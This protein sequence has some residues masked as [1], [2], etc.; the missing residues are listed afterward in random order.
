VSDTGPGIPEEK[1]PNIFERFYRLDPSRARKASGGTGLGLSIAYWITRSH[2]GNIEVE[3]KLGVG[4]TFTMRLPRIMDN[5]SQ[6]DG[7]MSATED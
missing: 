7:V 2:G 4:S 1:L 3:S 6:S 5:E